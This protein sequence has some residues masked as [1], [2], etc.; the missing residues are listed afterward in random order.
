MNEWGLFDNS[1]DS[2][3]AGETESE[4]YG[5]LDLEWIPPEMRENHGEIELAKKGS[6]SWIKKVENLID[7]A[8]LKGDL[9]VHS[10]KTDGQMSIEEMAYFAKF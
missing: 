4:I 3:L 5:L 2:K 9:Q 10:N 8:D 1:T 7:Y 6:M